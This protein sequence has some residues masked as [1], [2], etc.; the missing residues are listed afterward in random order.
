M[1]NFANEKAVLDVEMIIRAAE[2]LELP[3][4]TPTRKQEQIVKANEITLDL[5]FFNDVSFY[6]SSK[7]DSFS[8]SQCALDD[9]SG[10]K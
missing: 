9:C 8:R 2:Y 6:S 10:L 1:R 3:E 5:Q 4:P 7:T